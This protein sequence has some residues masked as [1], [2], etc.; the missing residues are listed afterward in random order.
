LGALEA[1]GLLAFVVKLKVEE[2]GCGL[3]PVLLLPPKPGN[4]VL[5]NALL[6]LDGCVGGK[7]LVPVLK[8]PF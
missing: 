4:E 6:W 3:K 8:P 2:G 5:A 7:L 1:N